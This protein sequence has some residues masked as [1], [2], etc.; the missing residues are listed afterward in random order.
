MT[1]N[2]DYSNSS[3][4]THPRTGTFIGPQLTRPPAPMTRNRL[5]QIANLGSQSGY[6]DAQSTRMICNAMIDATVANEIDGDRIAVAETRARE[7]ET[8]AASVARITDARLATAN[9]RLAK[10]ERA[11]GAS[12]LSAHLLEQALL[13]AR[14]QISALERQLESKIDEFAM[15]VMTGGCP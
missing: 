9:E 15:S 7:A 14:A 1:M 8:R 12:E 5:M 11:T 6:L 3:D 13:A 4:T 10:A 2:T